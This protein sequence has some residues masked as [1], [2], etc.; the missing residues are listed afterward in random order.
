MLDCLNSPGLG[1]NANAAA[2]VAAAVT[3]DDANSKRIGF[4]GSLGMSLI[5]FNFKRFKCIT[6]KASQLD[7]SAH[8]TVRVR[9]IQENVSETASYKNHNVL[10]TFVGNESQAQF[11]HFPSFL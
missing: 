1:F 8:H 5:F 4:F 11:A 9:L 10:H 6:I 7:C 2:D 3:A